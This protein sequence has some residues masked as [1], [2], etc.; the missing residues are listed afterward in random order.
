[1]FRI[2]AANHKFHFFLQVARYIAHQTR[3]LAES[4]LDGNHAGFQADRLEF[5]GDET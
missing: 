1:M 3:E 5:L 4:G 2:L